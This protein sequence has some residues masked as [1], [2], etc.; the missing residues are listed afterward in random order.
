M[1]S[2]LAARRVLNLMPCSRS[3]FNEPN[4]VSLHALTLLCQPTCLDSFKSAKIR[5]YKSRV[6]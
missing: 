2:S 1:T 5:G 3:T 6:M 4:T